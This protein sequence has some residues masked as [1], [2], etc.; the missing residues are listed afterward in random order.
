MWSFDDGG[1]AFGKVVNHTF[2]DNLA[3]NPAPDRSGKVV[4]TDPTGSRPP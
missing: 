1:V 2:N 3:G 4:I